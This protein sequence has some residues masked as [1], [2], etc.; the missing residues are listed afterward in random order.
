MQQRVSIGLASVAGIVG[1]VV[2][3]ITPAIG[4]LARASEPLGVPGTVWVIVAAV[5]ATV[6]I[7]GRVAQQIALDLRDGPAVDVDGLV[8][9]V[10]TEATDATP[11]GD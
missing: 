6:T 4:E 10:P 1:A 9:V 8:D 7:L 5:L 2:A 11:P 3:A